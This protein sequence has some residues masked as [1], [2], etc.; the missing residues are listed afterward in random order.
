MAMSMTIAAMLMPLLL[1]LEQEDRVFDQ[2]EGKN[3]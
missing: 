1:K 2:M 3:A